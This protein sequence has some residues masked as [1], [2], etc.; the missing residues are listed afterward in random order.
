MLNHIYIQ[1]KSLALTLA[2]TALALVASAQAPY[3]NGILPSYAAPGEVV[4]ISGSNFPTTNVVVFFGG[5]ISTNVEASSSLIKATVPLGATTEQIT[6]INTATGETAYSSEKFIPSFDGQSTTAAD[7]NSHLGD[8]LTFATSTT[9]AQDLCTCDFDKDGDLDVIV[10]SVGSSN[11]AVFTNISTSTESADVDFSRSTITNSFPVANVICGDLDGDGYADL[12]ANQV[13][14][15]GTLYVYRNNTATAGATDNISFDALQSLL[16]PNQSDGTFRKPTRIAM[17]DLDLDGHPE[18]LTAIEG[19]NLVFY[20]SNTSDRGTTP[21]V[22]SFDPTPSELAASINSGTSGLGGL[23]VADLNNDGFPEIITSNYTEAGFY[24]FHN[25]SEPGSYG[26]KDAAYF[27]TNA[28]IRMLKAGDLDNDGYMDLVLTN[29]DVTIDLIE[30]V[31]NTT[32][33]IGSDISL[34]SPI[35]LPGVSTSWGLDLG[36]IDGDGDLDISVASFGSNNFYVA[37]NNNPGTFAAASFDISNVVISQNSRNIKLA[38]MDGDAKADFVFTHNSGSGLPGSMAVKFNEICFVPEITATGSLKLCDSE[39][40]DLVAPI[41]GMTYIWKKNNVAISETS[42]IL[43]ISGSEA[44]SY[45]VAAND[46]CATDSAPIVVQSLS[47][48]YAQ[49]SFTFDI[50]APCVGGD[51]VLQVTADPSTASYELTGPNGFLISTTSLSDLKIDAVDA[52]HSG[53][54]TLTTTSGGVGCA[55]SSV[56]VALSVTVLPT[57]TVNNPLP[58]EFCTGTTVALSTS[59]F[60]GYAYEWKLDGASFSPAQT[61]PS[62]LNATVAGSYTVTILGSGCSHTSEPRL[63]TT[64]DPPVSSFTVSATTLCEEAVID[65]TATST[66]AFNIVNTWDFGD[67]ST[68]QTGNSVSYA[69]PASGSYTASLTA[70]YVGVDN[71]SYTPDTKTM[72]ITATPTGTQLDLIRSDNTDPQNYEKCAESSLLLRVQDPYTSYEW[73]TTTGTVLSTTTTASVGAEESV[74]VSLTDDLQCAF[75]A[76]PVLVTNYTNGGISITTTSPNQVTEDA[77]L[78]KIIELQDDQ[79]AVTLSVDA[80]SPTWEPSLYLD[81]PTANTVVATPENA[82]QLIEVIGIDILGC[83]ESDSVTLIKSGVQADKSFTPNGDGI[84][85]CWQISNINDTNCSI[86][87]FDT[88]GRR[89]RELSYSPSES[90]DDCVWDGKTSSGRDLPNGNYYYMMS[91][92]NSENQSAGAIFLAR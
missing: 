53:D 85:D 62:Q 60:A 41:T 67:G 91:C 28:S 87:I 78:G 63:L 11:L 49:P 81:N 40:V 6:V 10:S 64:V 80:T 68:T 51:V 54:Y 22:I 21:D 18:V 14:N 88:K 24:I 19:E 2:L 30:I 44:G 8:K 39:T 1:S 75:E 70:S 25:D 58:D 35:Q 26:F 38:D 79:Y 82:K 61:D 86:I 74:T 33:D 20:F 27:T 36:D 45:T 9:Q 73:K 50:S 48:T 15:E 29:S 4:N 76:N 32:A 89:I 52:S 5:A 56:P 59:T 17:G 66:G 71:C 23:E 16:I 72:T 12:V 69:Y 7:I 92:E 42:H 55:K 90:R 13:G 37:M 47:E 3:I 34:G 46:V 77:V 57:V 83:Q 43:T 31:Q 84:N 65:F